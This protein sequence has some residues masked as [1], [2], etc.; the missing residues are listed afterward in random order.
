MPGDLLLIFAD[1]LTRS[2]KQITKFRSATNTTSS[3]VVAT[4]SDTHG[5][6][7]GAAT[8]IGGFITSSPA[9]PAPAAPASGS[10][11]SEAAESVAE[12]KIKT[13]ITAPR[14]ATRPSRPAAP[15]DSGSSAGEQAE[16]LM[17]GL[18]RD[19]RGVRLAPE[20][21]D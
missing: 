18:I 17:P 15:R 6:G 10:A 13:S 19:E 1:A 11:R 21:E 12:R 4:A 16:S 2:W 5:P 8:G 3:A 7:D 9:A 14:E 20:I